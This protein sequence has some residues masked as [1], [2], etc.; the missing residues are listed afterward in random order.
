M[1]LKDRLILLVKSIFDKKARFIIRNKFGLTKNL[2]DEEYIRLQYESKFHRKL[3]L[4]NPKT[5]NEKV[6]WLKLFDRRKIYTILVDKYLVKQ[7]VSNVI[8]KDCVIP[9]IGVWDRANDIDFDKLPENFVL[10][11]THNSG[12][13]L[14]ICENKKYIKIDKIKKIL[15]SCLAENY[16]YHGREWPYKNV[17]PR[18]IA[19]KYMVDESGKELKDYKVF[20]FSGKAYC[21]QV[22]YDRFVDHHRNFYDLD[23]NYLP[24]TTLYPTNPNRKINKPSCL[25][26]LIILSEKLADSCGNPPLLRVDMYVIGDKCFFGELTFYH[27]SGTEE[28]MPLEWAYRLGDLIKLPERIGSKYGAK[29]SSC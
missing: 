15:N 12:K 4:D 21:I 22:D 24:F 29:D 27:G 1:K 5:F 3:D 7:F 11:C 25:K 17:K 10:K 6:Q 19:E 23:W 2:T 20:T 8:G 26:K 9:T 13:G 28:F 16:Y 14:F 18:I